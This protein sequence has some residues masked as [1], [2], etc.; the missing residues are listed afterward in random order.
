MESTGASTAAWV[1][2]E[3]LSSGGSS[4]GDVQGPRV[5]SEPATV[6][7]VTVP[8]VDVTPPPPRLWDKIEAALRQ[9]GRI[10]DADAD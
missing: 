10:R 2:E 3:D 9:E 8:L 4:G 7:L 6:S 1:R 5:A